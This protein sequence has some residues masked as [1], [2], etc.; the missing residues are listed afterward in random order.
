MSGVPSWVLKLRHVDDDSAALHGI[1]VFA[2]QTFMAGKRYLLALNRL[3]VCHRAFLQW[4]QNCN[5]VGMRETRVEFSTPS[6]Y[7]QYVFGHCPQ[8]VKG[9]S[10]SASNPGTISISNGFWSR[11]GFVMRARFAVT[12]AVGCGLILAGAIEA[13]IHQR[14]QT[15]VSLTRKVNFSDSVVLNPRAAGQHD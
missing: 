1:V 11:Q 12:V 8:S 5:S 2:S 14:A 9:T 10:E 13:T 4:R 15:R 3:S 7:Q 6:G